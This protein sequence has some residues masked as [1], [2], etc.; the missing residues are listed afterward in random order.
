MDDNERP[1]R[2]VNDFQTKEDLKRALLSK[3]KGSPHAVETAWFLSNQ[4]L[5]DL[6]LATEDVHA[7]AIADVDMEEVDQKLDWVLENYDEETTEKQSLDHEL[8]RLLVLKSYLLLDTETDAQFERVTGLASRLFKCPI[9]LISLVDLGRQ[10]FLSNRGLGDVR[11]TPRKLAFCAHAIMG[12]DD[13][14][15]V[16]PDATK[17]FRFKDNP[18]VTGLPSLRF[19]AGAP[20]VAPEGYKLGTLCV[21]DTKARPEGLRL[22]EKENLKDLAAMAVQ[23]LVDH[24]RMK[25]AWFNNNVLD[26]QG[27]AAPATPT[28][29]SPCGFT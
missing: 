6:V 10:F 20:L 8:H 12:K 7:V 11:E 13:D 1:N 29:A 9:A 15:L 23:T 22:E 26:R 28:G 5:Q 14:C 4:V 3:I 27:A 24:R 16:V 17:D 21:I 18:L 19:Y 2:S 25:S